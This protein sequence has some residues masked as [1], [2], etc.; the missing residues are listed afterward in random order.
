MSLTTKFLFELHKYNEA[1]SE[2]AEA[3]SI[4]PNYANAYN[5]RGLAYLALQKYDEA[6]SDYT[7]AILI[8]PNDS[9]AYY[10]RGVVYHEKGDCDN[11]KKDWEKAIELNP[12][13]ESDLR[14]YINN[15]K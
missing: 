7:N 14:A 6:I 13:F 11:A 10:Y 3:I 8:N 5:N 12:G 1:L 2:F 4:N 15:C 9:K